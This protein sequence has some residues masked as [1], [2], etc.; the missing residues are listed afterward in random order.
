MDIVTT[1]ALN[2]A[3]LRRRLSKGYSGRSNS[4]TVIVGTVRKYPTLVPVG[5]EAAPRSQVGLATK[6]DHL[7]G[8]SGGRFRLP[9]HD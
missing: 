1:N 8:S 7:E 4:V 3:F 5:P 9:A 2:I 6:F